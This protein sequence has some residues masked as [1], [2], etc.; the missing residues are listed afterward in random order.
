MVVVVIL[1]ILA[2]LVVPKLVG[3]TEEA[4]RTQARVQMKNL[5]QALEL[6][7]LDN[8]FYPDTEQGL[9][10][11]VT[12]PATGRPAK[13]WRQGGYLDRVPQDPWG[14]QYVYVSPGSAGAYD[15]MCYG[16]DG[17]PG[18]TGEDADVSSR[19]AK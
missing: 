18:G 5:E 8:G 11:L 10:A 1:G 9:S 19:D 13:G 7:K 16:A 4:K 3:R 15:L 6:F 17:A 12:A 2:A 14:N